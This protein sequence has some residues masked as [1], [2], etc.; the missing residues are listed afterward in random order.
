MLL[1]LDESGTDHKHAPYEVLGGI[2]IRER[3]LW[4]YVQAISDAQ[5]RCFGGVIRDVAPK[6]ELKGSTLLAKDKFAKARW[7][8]PCD[9][10]RRR[11]LA[12]SLFAK[13]QTGA[14][15]SPDELAALG[16]SCLIY[17]EEVLD[18]AIRFDVKVFASVVDAAAPRPSGDEFLRRDQAFLFERFYYYREEL[19]P[20]TRGLI[21]FDELEKSQCRGTVKRL[22]QYFLHTETG[23]TRA[24][25]I[26]PEPFFV[27]SDLTTGTQ[28]ADLIIY[29]INW[30]Y[31]FGE[32]DKGTR[33]ELLPCSQLIREMVYRTAR[34][35]E[36]G[37]RRDVWGVKYLDDL[38][39]TSQRP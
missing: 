3:D 6:W 5:Q 4:N 32:M 17:A 23:R 9:P 14:P 24:G 22:Q 28:T 37:G 27:H 8:P 19:P 2:A 20:D 34:S 38:R 39:P 16:Q 15:A 12:L 18:V 30:A 21:V 25:R 31:R 10:A 36:S 11:E 13:N 29:V 33:P 35:D 1:F 26:I 7:R